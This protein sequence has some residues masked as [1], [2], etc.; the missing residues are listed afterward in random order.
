MF[1]S[2]RTPKM[3]S[4]APM[5]GMTSVIPLLHGHFSYAVSRVQEAPERWPYSNAR[6]ELCAHYPL[7]PWAWKP[8]LVLADQGAD[9]RLI[10]DYLGHRN[11]QHTVQYTAPNPARLERLWR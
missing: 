2:I 4:T 11:I 7:N 5:H 3:K 10:Q 8:F 1:G 6:H 9:T